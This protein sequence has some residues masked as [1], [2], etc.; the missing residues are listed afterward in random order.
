MSIGGNPEICPKLCPSVSYNVNPI[1]FLVLKLMKQLPAMKRFN[2]L[3]HKIL[4]VE[5]NK[6]NESDIDPFEID[7]S[8]ET[9]YGKM[10]EE[11]CHKMIEGNDQIYTLLFSDKGFLNEDWHKYTCTESCAAIENARHGCESLGTDIQSIRQIDDSGC[12]LLSENGNML[13]NMIGSSILKGTDHTSQVKPGHLS[14]RFI[15]EGESH[16]DNFS[17]SESEIFESDF[18]DDWESCMSSA[19]EDECFYDAVSLENSKDTSYYSFPTRSLAQIL[20]QI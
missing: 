12:T 3:N 5:S 19:G 7:Y 13:T 20:R 14:D 9:L 8:L 18:E 11:S 4:D 6:L 16:I 15:L 17:E 1:E 2:L 10:D